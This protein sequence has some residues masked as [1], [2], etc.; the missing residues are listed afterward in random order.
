MKKLLFYLSLFVCLLNTVA[1]SQEV[2][3]QFSVKN[4][5][6]NRIIIGWVNQYPH[7]K[8]ISIQRS[9]DS[10][11]NFKTL[12][13]VP[14][15]T[16]LQNGFA[17]TKAPND[18]MYYRIFIGLGG[19]S[20]FFSPSK[21]PVLDLTT[22]VNTQPVAKQNTAKV[23]SNFVPSF[24]VYTNK[25]GYVFLNLPDADQKKYSIK[26]FE[27]D[28][29]FLFEIKQVKETAITLDKANFHHA[30]WFLFELYNSG[31]L[32]EKHKFYLEKDF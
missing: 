17:D 10:L 15:P 20:F 27:E 4:V 6:N 29:T 18:S 25:D 22:N 5:G 32:I 24:N 13:T 31:K 14:D 7:A 30:G 8:Q 19:G 26:F 2:L 11:K 1:F 3:P 23:F 12:L 16:A 21:R 28:G 9:Y